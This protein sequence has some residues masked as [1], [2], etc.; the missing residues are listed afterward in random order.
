MMDQTGMQADFEGAAEMPESTLVSDEADKV[1]EDYAAQIA[2]LSRQNEEYRRR[3]RKMQVDAMLDRAGMRI[4]I[5][6]D[7][8]SDRMMQTE[9][10]NEASELELLRERAPELFEGETA[11]FFAGALGND[12]RWE[13]REGTNALP[14]RNLREVEFSRK[15]RGERK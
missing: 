10:G 14:Y 11:P 7:A 2:A 4:G 8:I 12:G 13:E 1:R 6:R 3:L 9:E 15:K 5:A